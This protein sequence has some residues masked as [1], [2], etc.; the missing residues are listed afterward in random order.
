MYGNSLGKIMNAYDR[1]SKD[2]K[3][4]N[5]RDILEIQIKEYSDLNT[6]K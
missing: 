1:G 2:G 5:L 4:V 3:E 6:E